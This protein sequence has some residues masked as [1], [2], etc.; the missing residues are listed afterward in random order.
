[1]KPQQNTSFKKIEKPTG[2]YGV[3][4]KKVDGTKIT[5]KSVTEQKIIEKKIEKSDLVEEETK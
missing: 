5:S 2:T 4:S 1:M 3:G